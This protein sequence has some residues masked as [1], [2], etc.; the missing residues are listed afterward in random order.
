LNFSLQR[1]QTAKLKFSLNIN[2]VEINLP[3]FSPSANV[4]AVPPVTTSPSV[5]IPFAEIAIASVQNL[6]QPGFSLPE[7]IVFKI[8][9]K[10][11]THVAAFPTFSFFLS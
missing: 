1:D 11:L 7:Q 3:F 8:I 4:P 9:A 2:I 6:Q 5:S 10:G